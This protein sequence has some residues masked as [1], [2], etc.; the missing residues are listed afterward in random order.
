MQDR[1]MKTSV[2]D[3]VTPEF[4]FVS[5]YKVEIEMLILNFLSI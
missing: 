1:K 5:N 4:L 3:H 2:S